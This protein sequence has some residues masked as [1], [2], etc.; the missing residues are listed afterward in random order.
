M[1]PFFKAWNCSK[2]QFKVA[3]ILQMRSLRWAFNTK[4]RHFEKN[5]LVVQEGEVENHVYFIIDG[6]TL[7]FFLQRGERNFF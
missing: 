3:Q 4:I 1:R 7:E 6:V 5:T 2:K